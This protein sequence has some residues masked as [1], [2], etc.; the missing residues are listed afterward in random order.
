YSLKPF[1]PNR[2]LLA[3]R[4]M[5]IQFR[6][7]TH[8]D[9]WPIYEKAGRVPG[10]WKGW[11]EGKRF[12]L[13]LTHDVESPRGQS[14][15]L[16]LMGLEEK[17]GFRSSFYFPTDRYVHDE[18]VIRGLQEH[19]FE[20]GV[21]GVCHDGKLY[22]SREIFES[23]SSLI[24]EYLAKW[25]ACGFRSPS[26]LHRL[27]WIGDLDINYDSS[28][29]DTDPFEPQCCG[30]GTIFPFLV[31]DVTKEKSYVEL[32]YTMTQDFSLFVLMQ[33]KSIDIWKKKLDWIA[34]QGGMALM[35]THPDYMYM[36][37]GRRGSTE[38][39]VDF[40]EEILDYIKTRYG[41]EYWH[42]LP[43]EMAEFWRETSPSLDDKGVRKGNNSELLCLPCRQFFS[44]DTREKSLPEVQEDPRGAV[45]LSD[46]Q[47]EGKSPLRVC[48]MAY[49]FYE[50]DN[51]VKRYAEALARRGDEVDVIALQQLGQPCFKR[52]NG[53]N[54]YRIQ[55]RIINEKTK[56]TYLYRLLRFLIVSSYQVSRRHWAQRYD[57]VHVHSIPDFEVFAALVPKLSGARVI[58]DIHD[59]VPELY[60]DKFGV[61]QKSILFKCLK[62]LEKVSIGFSDHV[63]IAND[64]WREVLLSRSVKDDKCKVFL[65]Y[66]DP[67]IFYRRP[68]NLSNDKFIMIYPGTLLHHQGLDIAIRAL[69]LIANEAP[70]A[71]FQIYGDGPHKPELIR[72]SQELGLADKV[73][74]MDFM[75]MEQVA[76][77]MSQADLGVVP[78]RKDT[79]GNE[80]F[81]TKIF[82]FMSLGV[83][84]VAADTKID[85]FYFNDS[86]IRFFESGD[87]QDLARHI[88]AMI[89][90][91]TMRQRQVEN[92]LEFVAK[93]SWDAHQDKYFDL[94]EQLKH[95]K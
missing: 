78:K 49:T 55:K 5:F 92:A 94:I 34:D 88:L 72:M 79:F 45:V 54:V 21:H 1:I 62:L 46:S 35:L 71:E 91:E 51:R 75:P 39:P 36:G 33:K 82:E 84:V 93:Y 10:G 6:K 4:R 87:E 11:R 42:A 64:L 19:G 29:T 85:K 15:C 44:E 16:D 40:Y 38:Y 60:A 26:M 80:A 28:T 83:P 47:A 3:L 56:F 2:A 69:S 53:I 52:E 89:K 81:S 90:D 23:R 68:R 24:N 76:E 70:E 57:V 7:Y 32:P 14:Q 67:N 59:I 20:V 50:N 43:R 65:N 27:D 30:M 12:A 73:V 9:I 18:E 77:A 63:I 37:G 25:Q 74:F 58:L 8:R 61:S 13:V 41:G 86:V 48:M 95:K 31:G 22:K 17:L 66:P